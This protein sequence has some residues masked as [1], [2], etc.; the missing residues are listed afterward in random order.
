MFPQC[1]LA[2][3]LVVLCLLIQLFY[4]LYRRRDYE[5]P[6]AG[7]GGEVG[8]RVGRPE[9]S[10]ARREGLAQDVRAGARRGGLCGLASDAAQHHVALDAQTRARRAA[11]RRALAA[12][13][14]AADERLL[15]C[16]A[17]RG[18]G[19]HD[20]QPDVQLE[21]RRQPR[22]RRPR[23]HRMGCAARR[24]AQTR[25]ER[26]HPALLLLPVLRVQVRR[27]ERGADACR[28][29][30]FSGV[31]SPRALAVGRRCLRRLR[32]SATNSAHRSDTASQPHNGR[33]PLPSRH[34]H[35]A[36]W[37]VP[38]TADGTGYTLRNGRPARRRND[39][40]GRTPG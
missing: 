14:G 16:A 26:G 33:H 13:A 6:L 10:G 37:H 24:R 12:D 30:R 35:A 23:V 38:A 3:M 36:R 5:R 31:E 18:D 15:W 17:G 39:G 28:R 32:Q 2:L 40:D 19:R 20:A 22:G 8:L 1:L 11:A 9:R 4:V 27:R 25:A 21:L 7:A 34:R 29:V